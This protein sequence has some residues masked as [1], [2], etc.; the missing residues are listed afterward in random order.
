MRALREVAVDIQYRYPTALLMRPSIS[1]WNPNKAFHE[2]FP[3][4]H[5]LKETLLIDLVYGRVLSA[6]K[7]KKSTLHLCLLDL[8]KPPYIVYIQYH[9]PPINKSPTS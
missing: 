1:N 9:T 8:R 4:V 3:V 7:K 2:S 5:G 6:E